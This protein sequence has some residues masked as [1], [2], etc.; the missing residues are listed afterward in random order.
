MF[1]FQLAALKQ[2]LS[3]TQQDKDYFSKQVSDLQN[4]LLYMEDRVLQLND[5]LDRAKNSREE[6]YDKY[7]A[8][9]Y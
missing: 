2:S 3:L 9:R 7:V 4:K 5:Q 6:L 8:S 1:Y